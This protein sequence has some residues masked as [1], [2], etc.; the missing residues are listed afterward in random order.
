M[1]RTLN[2]TAIR[3]NHFSV[4][5]D[6]DGDITF[7]VNYAVETAEGETIER[8]EARQVSSAFKTQLEGIFTRVEAALNTKEGL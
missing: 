1:P 6:G 4:Q 3:F 7:S 5:R 8:S 2:K